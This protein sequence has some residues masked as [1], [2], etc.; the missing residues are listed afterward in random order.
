MSIKSLSRVPVLSIK[1]MIRNWQ[2]LHIQVAQVGSCGRLACVLHS[3][4]SRA[5]ARE[6]GVDLRERCLHNVTIRDWKCHAVRE[7]GLPPICKVR[8]GFAMGIKMK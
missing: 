5:G 6:M 4:A 7:R 1:T 8:I 3:R 2:T